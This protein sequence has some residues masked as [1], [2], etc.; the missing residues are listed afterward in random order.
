MLITSVRGNEGNR[1]KRNTKKDKD[2]KEQGATEAIMKGW[3]LNN[4][5]VRLRFSLINR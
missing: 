5:V 2:R 3:G 1:W 4:F